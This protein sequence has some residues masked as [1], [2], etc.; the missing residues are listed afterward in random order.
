MQ[1]KPLVHGARWVPGRW[2]LLWPFC[3]LSLGMTVAVSAWRAQHV[4]MIEVV[5]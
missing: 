1:T 5:S 4:A 2:C 3:S